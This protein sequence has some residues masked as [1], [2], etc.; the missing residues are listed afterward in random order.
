MTPQP[1]LAGVSTRPESSVHPS[2]FL[3]P[4]GPK[5][6]ERAEAPGPQG[7]GGQGEAGLPTASLHFA[8]THRVP[9]SSLVWGLCP[10]KKGPWLLKGSIQGDSG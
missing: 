1:G 4:G 10:G 5:E 9:L 6:A 7:E 2:S 8:D 3:H